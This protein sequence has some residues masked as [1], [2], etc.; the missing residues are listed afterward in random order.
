MMPLS[1]AGGADLNPT[2]AN[3]PIAWAA[4]PLFQSLKPAE[5]ELLRPL[6]RSKSYGEGETVFREGDPALAFHFILGGKVKIVKMTPSG[7]DFILEILGPGDPVGAI[8]A[9]EERDFPASA[10]TLEATT[11][12]S[13]PRQELFSLLASNP[14]LARA[15]LLGLTRRMMDLTRKLAERSSRVE[16]RIA[17]LFLA[18]ADRTGRGEGR[19]IRIPV[20]LTRQ[21][22]ADMV[23]TTQE[24]AIRIMS[25][26][27][28]ENLVV[29]DASGFLV[30]DRRRLEVIPPEE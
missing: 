16:Y 18:F 29:T 8:A 6:V 1:P 11:L 15:L 12:I 22:I 26:W 30:P 5:R 9:Y 23:G 21:E 19:A 13:L 17:R 20:A 10:V 25:R 27:G 3:H 14:I 4:I 24:T 7:R 2:D 28:K